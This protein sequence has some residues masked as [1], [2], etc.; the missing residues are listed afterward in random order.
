MMMERQVPGSPASPAVPSNVKRISLK[1]D[2]E[3]QY[4]SHRLNTSR[5]LLEEAVEHVG[6]N[7]NA[8]AD[9][10]SQRQ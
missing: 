3:V 10:L 7:V 1:R 8:V 9:Y 4:W 6:S 2:I 5:A